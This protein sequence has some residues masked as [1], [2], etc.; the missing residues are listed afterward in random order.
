MAR[1]L[2]KGVF[3]EVVVDDYFPFDDNGN[4]LSASPAGGSE[5]WVMILQK[6]WAK[7]YGSYKAVDGGFPEEVLRAISS[8]PTYHFEMIEPYINDEVFT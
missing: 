4:L 6:C 1:I 7:L 5:I 8:A 2:H 3:Q